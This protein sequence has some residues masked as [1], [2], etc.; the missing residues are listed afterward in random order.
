MSCCF[1]IPLFSFL[2]LFPANTAQCHE[3]RGS[4]RVSTAEHPPGTVFNYTL[5]K[6]IMVQLPDF[7]CLLVSPNVF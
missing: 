4:D 2:H 5:I 6:Q 7:L 3:I 1:L